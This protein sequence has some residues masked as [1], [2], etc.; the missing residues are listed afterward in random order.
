[1]RHVSWLSSKHMGDW[2]LL[3]PN[4]DWGEE[5]VDYTD[6]I[7]RT[8]AI[9]DRAELPEAAKWHRA[10]EYGDTYAFA[11]ILAVSAASSPVP[12]S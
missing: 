5:K 11:A 4:K 8:R 7:E 10:L 9:V 6:V 2:T 1:M 12:P 3:E